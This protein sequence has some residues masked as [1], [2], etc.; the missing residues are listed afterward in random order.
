[1]SMDFLGGPL[2]KTGL[3][4][5]RLS[6][7]LLSRV[8][9]CNPMDCS[10]PDSS[11]HGILQ[12]RTLEWVA[13]SSSRGSSQPRILASP[14]LAGRFFTTEPVKHVHFHLKKVRFKQR[15][16]V[17]KNYRDSDQLLQWTRSLPLW[18]GATVTPSNLPSTLPPACRIHSRRLCQGAGRCQIWPHLKLLL[19][20]PCLH[21]AFQL[22]PSAP[23]SY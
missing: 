13:M 4:M 6:E 23:G 17:W 21:F 19:Q 7:K 8:R 15:V 5:Q 20:K 16:P 22:F 10:P 9:L 1:M 3:V 11:V 2:I 12:A 14:A 18:T